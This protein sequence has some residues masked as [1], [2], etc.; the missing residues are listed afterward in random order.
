MRIATHA[1]DIDGIVSA[2]LILMKYPSA[3]IDFLTL[4]DIRNM[5]DVDYDLVVDLPKLPKAKVNIDHHISNYEKLVKEK[6]LTENDIVDPKAPSAASLI[7]N[8]L[9]LSDNKRAKELVD[10]ANIADTGGVNKKIY[11]L[12]KIIKCHSNEPNVLLKI[13]WILVERGLNFDKDEWIKNEWKRLKKW[14]DKGK[15]ISEKVAKSALKKGVKYLIVDLVAGFPRLSM[16]DVQ[17]NFIN[18]GGKVIIL[19]N[20]M[21]EMDP[22]CPKIIKFPNDNTV[23]ISLRVAKD[24]EFNGKQLAERLGGGGHIRAAGARFFIHEYP[25]ALKI[26]FEELAKYGIVGYIKVHV[27]LDADR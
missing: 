11:M 24:C 12:D 23:R 21:K 7:I 1:S 5:F 10:F 6:R 4:R 8:Y 17:W 25:R 19:V 18:R 15:K 2:A 14:L 3:K 22:V 13:A 9:D 16:S 26:M 27:N 20:R